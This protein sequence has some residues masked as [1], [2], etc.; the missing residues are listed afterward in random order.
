MAGSLGNLVQD[1]RLNHRVELL[2]GVLE[3]ESAELLRAFFSRAP[4][5]ERR[6]AGRLSP[7]GWGAAGVPLF[8][9]RSSSSTGVPKNHSTSAST[10]I[11][12]GSATHTG[13][14]SA[15]PT[16]PSTRPTAPTRIA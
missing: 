8:Y 13:R 7:P 2:G 14:K 12:A 9:V 4:G 16:L 6:E 11:P 15:V 5:W 10:A 3:E 1:S